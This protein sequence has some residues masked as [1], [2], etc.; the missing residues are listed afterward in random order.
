MREIYDI[1]YDELHEHCKMIIQPNSE[2]IPWFVDI[3]VEKRDELIEFLKLHNIQT[4][5][6]Y[7]E[8]NKTPMYYSDINYTVSSYVS[9]CGLFLPTHSKITNNEIYHIC[10][11]IKLFLQN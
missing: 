9:R 3:F 5:A 10:K 1:Y 7:P 2:W 11:L 8:I 4:R 6:T